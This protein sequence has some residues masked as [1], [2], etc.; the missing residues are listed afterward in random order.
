MRVIPNK[1]YKKILCVI[2][3]RDGSVGVVNK[4]LQIIAGE[5]L[6]EHSIFHAYN[7]G[8]SQKNI[9]VSSDSDEILGVAATSQCMRPAVVALCRPAS[10]SGPKSSTEEAL[11][12]ALKKH[13]ESHECEHVLL[14]QATSPIRFDKTVGRFIDFYLQGGYDSALTTTK[15]CNFFWQSGTPSTSN[16]DPVN[17]PMRQSLTEQDYRHFD[18]GNMYITSRKVLEEKKCRLGDNVG[19]FP[20]SELE[21]MQID[22][23]EDL[24]IMRNVLDGEVLRKT[25]P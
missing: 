9:Y 11:L 20:I 7:A 18:N 15:F 21:G 16:Y 1:K 4:N 17:R 23:P 24:E 13:C 5:T 25:Y 14:L 10:I 19:L 12:H 8:L 22:T 3:A 6:I 2:P